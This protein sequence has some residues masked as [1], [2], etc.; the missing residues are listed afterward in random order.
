MI[1]G[2]DRHQYFNEVWQSDDLEKYWIQIN[3]IPFDERKG[4][5]A[6]NYQGKILLIGGQNSSI[7]MDLWR[8]E[9][10]GKLWYKQ[11]HVPFEIFEQEVVGDLF[12]VEQDHVWKSIDEGMTWEKGLFEAPFEE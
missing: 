3:N 4:L 10:Q 7:L 1:G 2:Y 6:I 5:G 11:P 12:V 8:S 9:E